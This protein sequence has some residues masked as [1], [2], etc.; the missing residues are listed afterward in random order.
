MENAE[1]RIIKWRRKISS[2][3]FMKYKLIDFKGAT[4]NNIDV[5]LQGEEIDS[6]C[7]DDTIDG[8]YDAE[9]EIVFFRTPKTIRQIVVFAKQENGCLAYPIGIYDCI[10]S[11]DNKFYTIYQKSALIQ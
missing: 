9:K 11:P 7:C 10:P 2:L 1:S 8:V 4:Y 6:K 3:R 5:F